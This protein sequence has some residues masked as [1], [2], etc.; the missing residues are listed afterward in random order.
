[1]YSLRFSKIASVLILKAYWSSNRVWYLICYWMPFFCSIFRSDGK[2]KLGIFD[3][4]SSINRAFA[5]NSESDDPKFYWFLWAD[6]ISSIFKLL[7][8]LELA[9]LLSLFFWI[10]FWK[11][12]SKLSRFSF[13][14][15]EYGTTSLIM[16]FPRKMLSFWR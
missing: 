3:W 13:R 4:P 9:T 16:Y 5:C 6:P 2:S 10:C 14:I 11:T 7:G 8:L 15:V 1:M 12:E